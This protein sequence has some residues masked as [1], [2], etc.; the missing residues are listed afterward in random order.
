MPGEVILLVD[1]EPN[2]VELARL[3]LEREGYRIAAAGDGAKAMEA[4]KKE[5]P[6]IVV[7]DI[8]LP[9]I[10]GYEVCKRVRAGSKEVI[11]VNNQP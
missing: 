11:P 2:I 1:D 9:A 3:Y 5:S 7:L 4:I 10:D 8:M 6:A